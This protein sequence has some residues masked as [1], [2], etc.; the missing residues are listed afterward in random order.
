MKR[1][2]FLKSLFAPLLVPFLPKLGEAPTCTYC[3]EPAE[4]LEIAKRWFCLCRI[5]EAEQPP[6]GSWPVNV[7]WPTDPGYRYY[8]QPVV[9]PL[10][11]QQQA[12]EATE[13]LKLCGWQDAARGKAK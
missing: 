10:Y 11:A 4:W 12:E 5:R 2:T 13:R 3:G 8:G 7:H 6:L 1:T 9:P